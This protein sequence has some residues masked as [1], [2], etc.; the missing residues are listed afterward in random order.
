M[1][2]ATTQGG[3][4]TVSGADYAGS[5]ACAVVGSSGYQGPE[6]MFAVE[7]PGT[8]NV[9]ITLESP[10]EDLDLF[11]AYW[12]D[13]EACLRSGV[14]VSECEGDVGSG[15][16]Q[17]TIWNNRSARYVA[18]VEGEAGEEAPF[19]LRVDCE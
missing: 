7:H 18:I 16:N 15:E 1:I 14:S 13:D 6:R 10:C 4:S 17:I 3:L 11:A 19:R 12:L 5:W 9:Q 2:E 8:G